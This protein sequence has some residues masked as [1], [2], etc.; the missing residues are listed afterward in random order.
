MGMRL[1]VLQ[2]YGNKMQETDQSHLGKE[3]TQESMSY[4]DDASCQEGSCQEG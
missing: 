3:D 2:D 4:A 1:V